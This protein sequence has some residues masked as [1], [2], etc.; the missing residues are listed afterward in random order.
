MDFDA[1]S[2]LRAHAAVVLG[3]LVDATGQTGTLTIEHGGVAIEHPACG[4]V[5]FLLGEHV[6]HIASRTG[7][8]F[9]GPV[10]VL[11]AHMSLAMLLPSGR[12]HGQVR[13]A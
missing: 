7:S 8:A 5:V 9:T 11:V 2:H 1:V 6:L 3:A 4:R 13:P 12:R 10:D